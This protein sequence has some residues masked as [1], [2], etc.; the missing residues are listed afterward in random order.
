MQSLSS[1]IAKN[2]FLTREK[3]SE[4]GDK[5]LKQMDRQ[6]R[7]IA[8]FKQLS[9]RKDA[10]KDATMAY[11]KTLITS[12]VRFNADTAGKS[13]HSDGDGGHYLHPKWSQCESSNGKE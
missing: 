9:L 5:L 2:A 13:D 12:S 3:F 10:I 7:D 11:M 6:H 8:D 1:H 4:L